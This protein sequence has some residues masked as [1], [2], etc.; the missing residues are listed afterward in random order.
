MPCTTCLAFRTRVEC[1][2]RLRVEGKPKHPDHQL[3]S[4]SSLLSPACLLLQVNW[5]K[6]TAL[7]HLLGVL[8]LRGCQDVVALYIGDDHTDEDAFRV[9]RDTHS[10]EQQLCACILGF[11]VQHVDLVCLKEH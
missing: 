4:V 2:P 11:T 5:H 1:Q 3:T 9:L 10:G 6:G 7:D 8:G